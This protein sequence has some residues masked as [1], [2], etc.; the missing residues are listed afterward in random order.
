MEK[1]NFFKKYNIL[2]IKMQKILFLSIFLLFLISSS[3]SL[4]YVHI[5][6]NLLKRILNNKDIYIIDTRE[7]DVAAQGYVPNSIIVPTSLSYYLSSVVPNRSSIVVISDEQNYRSV[8]DDLEESRRRYRVLGYCLYD[9]IKNSDLFDIQKVDYNQNTKSDVEEI[10]RDK[11]N[12]IDLRNIS[13]FQETGIVPG[14]IL[15]PLVDFLNEYK[16]IPREG[17]VY[18]F[19]KRALR[20]VIGMTFAKRAGYTNHFIIMKEGI[21]KTVDEG[22]QLEPYKG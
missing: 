18:V 13:E 20:A 14:S 7:I 17:D 5:N 10:V 11:R 1:N 21:E 22:Y 12:I 19:C 15:I 16:K 9:E 6:P 4:K 8:L 3:S 2:K